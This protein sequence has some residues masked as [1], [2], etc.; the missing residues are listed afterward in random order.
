MTQKAHNKTVKFLCIFLTNI[1][2]TLTLAWCL[3]IHTLWG[4]SNVITFLLCNSSFFSGFNMSSLCL[5]CA[6][7]FCDIVKSLVSFSMSFFVLLLC[8]IKLWMGQKKA[9]ETTCK[10]SFI[11]AQFSLTLILSCRCCFIIIVVMI[12]SQYGPHWKGFDFNFIMCEN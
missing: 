1:Y 11:V 10:T 9:S 8:K 12:I 2:N 5:I 4:V 7:S 3:L 6:I